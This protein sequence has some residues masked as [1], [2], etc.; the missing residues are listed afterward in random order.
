MK[1]NSRLI[2]GNNGL[3]S[4]VRSGWHNENK[5]P[6]GS[7]INS[8]ALWWRLQERNENISVLL[9]RDDLFCKNIS[10]NF[11]FGCI[12][13][14]NSW[15]SRIWSLKSLSRSWS[16]GIFLSAIEHSVIRIWI[17]L[18]GIHLLKSSLFTLWAFL[19]RFP[20]SLLFQ[21]RNMKV[22]IMSPTGRESQDRST[23]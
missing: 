17:M 10:F 1:E 23:I 15:T 16:T 4:N 13:L 11:S 7:S 2:T 20:N 6:L 18:L 14:Y 3:S 19:W 21:M 9:E 22:L 5:K 12:Y 8:L